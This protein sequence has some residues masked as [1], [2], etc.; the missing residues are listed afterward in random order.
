M[1]LDLKKVLDK[2]ESFGG[3]DCGMN[4]IISREGTSLVLTAHTPDGREISIST[5]LD[6]RPSGRA[7]LPEHIQ[8]ELLKNTLQTFRDLLPLQ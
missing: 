8:N 2:L 1:S 4:L 3:K 5:V 7:A 6:S